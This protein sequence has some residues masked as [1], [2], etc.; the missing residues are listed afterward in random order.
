MS[1]SVGRCACLA[2]I[3]FNEKRRL[4]RFFWL[5]IARAVRGALVIKGQS[6]AE[7]NKAGIPRSARFLYTP[8]RKQLGN[9]T[10]Q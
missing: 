1:E 7:R 9:A 3:V 4:G 5:L 10:K 2:T 8:S 6:Q